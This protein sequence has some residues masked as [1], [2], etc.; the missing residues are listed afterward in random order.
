VNN[1]QM[2]YIPV[3]ARLVTEEEVTRFQAHWWNTLVG[4]AEQGYRKAQDWVTG[5]EPV[6]YAP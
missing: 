3:Q 6:D 2:L 1:A 5:E 4:L